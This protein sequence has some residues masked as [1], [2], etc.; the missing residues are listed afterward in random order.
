MQDGNL[1][2]SPQEPIPPEL[3]L[4]GLLAQVRAELARRDAT[5]QDARKMPVLPGESPGRE[6]DW[7][8]ITQLLAEAEP[9]ADAGATAPQLRGLPQPLR[10]LGRLAAQSLLLGARVVTN[11]QRRFNHVTLRGLRRL[12]ETTRQLDTA[13][14]E[15]NVFIR[16][17]HARQQARLERLPST[18]AGHDQALRLHDERLRQLQ[19]ALRRHQEHLRHLHDVVRATH[20]RFDEQET[21]IVRLEEEVKRLR[22][23]RPELASQCRRENAA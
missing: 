15:L 19:Q 5:A 21:R 22:E 4:A 12:Q 9:F 10:W 20:E 23:A 1:D 16:E 2:K 8:E 14:A 11:R 13:A 18:V 17:E 7:E 6:T 3:H